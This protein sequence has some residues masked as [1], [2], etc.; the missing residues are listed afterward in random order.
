MR[1]LSEIL[2]A[3]ISHEI[4]HLLGCWHTEPTAG[5]QGLTDSTNIARNIAGP[6]GAGGTPDDATIGF[7]S[8][9]RYLGFEGLTGTEDTGWRV[10][11]GLRRSY[12]NAVPQAE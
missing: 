7:A 1:F 2:G 6:D 8:G 5:I 10:R 3:Y 4:G 12:V 11:A 9:N